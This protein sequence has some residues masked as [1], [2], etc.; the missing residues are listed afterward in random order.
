[1]SPVTPL[2]MYISQPFNTQASGKGAVGIAGL[3]TPAVIGEVLDA[4]VFCNTGSLLP[5]APISAVTSITINTLVSLVAPGGLA[6]AGLRGNFR[7]HAW[8]GRS[9]M[10]GKPHEPG[11]NPEPEAEPKP[12]DSPPEQHPALEALP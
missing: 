12:M 8:S 1:M 4:P 9:N 7:P 5:H 3:T 6:Y 11:P 2:V 10:I